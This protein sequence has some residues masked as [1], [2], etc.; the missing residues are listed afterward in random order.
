MH[1]QLTVLSPLVDM[2]LGLKERNKFE[3]DFESFPHI[4]NDQKNGK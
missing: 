1:P 4:L 3:I 2:G